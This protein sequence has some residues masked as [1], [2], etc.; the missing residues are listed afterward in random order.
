MHGRTSCRYCGGNY[1]LRGIQA[2]E[3]WC[4][5]NPNRGTPPEQ[6]SET[7]SDAG[8]PLSDQTS[9][10]P[11]LPESNTLTPEQE[12]TGDTAEKGCPLCGESEVIDAADARE[13]L[14]QASRGRLPEKADVA[15]ALSEW[16]CTNPDC[17]AVWTERS[18]AVTM[19]AVMNA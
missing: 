17:G 19:E 8:G 4:S 6:Q 1:D 15:L 14:S 11:E 9:E 16:Y 18:E 3:Q 10:S 5:E 12:S 13:R 7:G 2:H